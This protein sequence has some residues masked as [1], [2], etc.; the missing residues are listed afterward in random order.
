MISLFQSPSILGW[1]ISQIKE[2]KD[3]QNVLV[4]FDIGVVYIS[5][6]IGTRELTR[7]QSPSILGWSIS[8]YEARKKLEIRFSP[9]RYWG[10]LYQIK[11]PSQLRLGF[12]PLRYWGGLYPFE[13][14]FPTKFPVLVPFDIGVVYIPSFVFSDR[15]F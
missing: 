9:L 1:S 8:R 7:F 4:P 13:F 15:I 10:G 12:S 5:Y 3:W 6:K 2:I 14:I 11:P